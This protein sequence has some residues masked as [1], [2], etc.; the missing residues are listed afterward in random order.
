[1]E[2]FLEALNMQAAGRGPGGKES[3]RAVSDNIWT[4]L[5]LCLSSLNA[6][7]LEDCV[8]KR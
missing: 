7:H 3:S 1:M 5:R 6:K 8:N 2:H 4:T